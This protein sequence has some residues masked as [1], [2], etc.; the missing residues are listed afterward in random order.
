[1]H[2]TFRSA[3]N[4]DASLGVRGV[5]VALGNLPEGSLFAHVLPLTSGRR[6]KAGQ[7]NHAVAAVFV[8]K[9]GPNA[10][11]PLEAIARLYKLT[12][13]ELRIL[14]ALLKA[15]GIKAM[16]NMLGLSQATVNTHLHNLF[17]KTGTTRQSDLVKLV[18]L[19]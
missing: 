12:A 14:D 9:T 15:N 2:N 7:A 8:R 5:A 17:R 6:Q 16:A 11:S 1:L 19:I 18:A 10:P 4:G 3:A 13:G